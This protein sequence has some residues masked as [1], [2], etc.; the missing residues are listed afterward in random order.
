M[1]RR[2]L[3]ANLIKAQAVVDVL[4]EEI[5]A[6]ECFLLVLFDEFGR[7]IAEDY[8]LLFFILPAVEFIYVFLCPGVRIL[9]FGF[10]LYFIK[11]AKLFYGNSCDR[12]V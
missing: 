3:T 2:Y 11:V 4:E 1:T 5:S 12:A 7:C 8:F 6:V 9:P 10:C